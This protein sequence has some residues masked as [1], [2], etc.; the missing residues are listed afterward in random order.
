MLILLKSI[1]YNMHI[2]I[3][4]QFYIDWSFGYGYP[5]KIKISYRVIII[6]ILF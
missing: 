1:F 3:N 5:I 2:Y 6:K 4:K